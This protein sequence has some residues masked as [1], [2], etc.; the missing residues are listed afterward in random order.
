MTDGKTDTSNALW[1]GRFS[2]SP[3]EIMESINA[4]IDVD[5]RMAFED[6]AG[7]IAHAQML[8]ATAIIS[9]GDAAKIEQGLTQIRAEIERG[10]MQ[11]SKALE[12][13]HMN[14]EARLKEIIGAAAGR[15]HT[16]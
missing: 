8:A 7:S 9:S 14:I 1:G 5:Q 12:D 16:A 4:S 6:I 10:E 3:S 2:G 11:W 13:V 15:L